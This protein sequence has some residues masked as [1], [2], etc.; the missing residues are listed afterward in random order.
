MRGDMG[1]LHGVPL[2]VKDLI[3]TRDLRTTG[4]SEIY[5]GVHP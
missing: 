2:G 3:F 1:P 5:S 4:G